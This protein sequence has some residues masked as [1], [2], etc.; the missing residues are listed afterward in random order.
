MPLSRKKSGEGVFFGKNMINNQYF[1]YQKI[2]YVI[3][4]NKKVCYY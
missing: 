2:K 3:A 4:D 1:W